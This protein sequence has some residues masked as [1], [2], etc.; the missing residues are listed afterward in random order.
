[1]LEYQ[2]GCVSEAILLIMAASKQHWFHKLWRMHD[3]LVC[4]SEKRIH[5]IRP[6]NT[7]Q[8]LR[9][10]TCFVYLGPNE[11][12]FIEHFSKFGT[13]ARRIDTPPVKPTM[14]ELW[15]VAT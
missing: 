9:E 11:D 5:F 2:S 1:V 3:G 15:E 4:F 10:S 13:I 8:E 6:N 7:T 12:R 14:R